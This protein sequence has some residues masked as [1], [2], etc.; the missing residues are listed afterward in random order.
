MS[1]LQGSS[2]RHAAQT[3]ADLQLPPDTSSQHDNPHRWLG[4]TLLRTS[5]HPPLRLTTLGLVAED[6][7]PRTKE[8]RERIAETCRRYD[9]GK[10]KRRPG[11]TDPT[12][13]V[14]FP[15]S[16]ERHS[17]H[18]PIYKAASTSRLWFMLA[19]VSPR[20][21][22]IPLVSS[23]SIDFLS[24]TL[25]VLYPPSFPLPPPSDPFSRLVSPRRVPPRLSARSNWNVR[26]TSSPTLK[27]RKML[28]LKSPMVVV[29]N[30]LPFVLC[31]DEHGKLHRKQCAGGLVT[32]VAPVVIQCGGLWVG[33]PGIHMDDPSQH[34]PESDP[35]DNGPSAGL[36]SDQVVPVH[37]E[38]QMFD[39][40]YNGCCNATFWPLFHSMPDRAVFQVDKWEA[41]STANALF[42]HQTVEAL[43]KLKAQEEEGEERIPLVWIHDY[44]LMLAAN[45]IRQQCEEENL[46]CK[47]GFFL[48]IPFP[49]WDI[50]RLFP[51]DDEVLQGILGCDM[52]G[53][54]IEDYCR[55]FLDCCQR[56]LGFRVDRLH[57]LV[58]VAG[59]TVKVRALPI[60][61]PYK[62][63]EDMANAATRTLQSSLQIILGV[64]RL[65]YTKGII[66]SRI[67]SFEKLLEKHPEHLEK[68]ALLQVAVPSRTDVK[69]YQQ[70]KEQIDLE[71]GRINGR[72]STLNWSPI[73]YIYGCISQDDLAAYYS[74]RTAAIED[75]PVLSTTGG[76]MG[77]MHASVIEIRISISVEG[78]L[79]SYQ[80][81]SAFHEFRGKIVGGFTALQPRS[82]ICVLFDRDSS[83]ALVTPLRDGMNLVAKEYVACQVDKPGVL[84]LSPFAGAGETM[85]EALLVN[86]YELDDVAD[87][88]HRALTMP[89][90]E[91][92]MR[93]NHLRK[94][95][96]TMNL[97]F[98]LSNFLKE[99]KINQKTCVNP[100]FQV[101]RV[102]SE[103]TSRRRERHLFL[104]ICT[105]LIISGVELNLGPNYTNTEQ[106]RLTD[107][108][109]L[110]P[111]R[112]ERRTE[113]IDSEDPPTPSN[114]T[115]E[116][117]ASMIRVTLA[118]FNT[119]AHTTI[120]LFHAPHPKSLAQME[121]DTSDLIAS[122]ATDRQ[123]IHP[124]EAMGSFNFGEGQ[125]EPMT[126]NTLGPMTMED[127]D[128]FLSDY[129]GDTAK[130][131]LL[132]DYDGT[133]APIAPKP[134]IAFMPA[135]TKNILA[136][137]SN[138]SD[139]AIAIVS[140]RSLE[141][142]QKMVG[143]DGITYAGNHGL[144]ILHPDG[145]KFIYPIPKEYHEKIWNMCQELQDECCKD[146]AWI[147]H[148]GPIITYHFRAVPIQLRGTFK[149]KATAIISKNGFKVHRAH[150]AIE[151]RP[152]IQWDKGRASIYILRTMFG[153]DWL[154]RVRV[155]YVGDD[156]TDEDALLALHGMA[157][158]FRIT[159]H[160]LIR[161]AATKRLSSTDSV[162][163][164]LKW[165]ER[166]ISKR[167]MRE[168][169]HIT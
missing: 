94:R 113:T 127:F 96:Q 39:D 143:I 17:A 147:E 22:W 49:P 86:P 169:P 26:A 110:T 103:H 146:G 43:K 27:G 161:T 72:F 140:G 80:G 145:S 157:C 138:S 141:D 16:A 66:N 30:R 59:R 57:N 111:N 36:R 126:T 40:F 151:A 83:V 47:L 155:I 63:F 117:I 1:P 122:W 23:P 62:R 44:H 82:F 21:F 92:E 167:P 156:V 109:S 144:E 115:L 131:A 9:L 48:H 99:E 107:F 54:H 152:P 12:K 153:V 20:L 97:D 124:L 136:R 61:I 35:E 74:L 132:L 123:I 15:P 78:S 125:N 68:V 133:L 69:E 142:V 52:I 70:L 112:G 85:H 65:D 120:R 51:W 98:W 119:I 60:G 159:S 25:P 121:E 166:H 67:L 163:T 139:V 162:L 165:V 168:E 77:K 95:E 100:S 14:P 5:L 6:I 32:A 164:L 28:S 37:M 4:G 128:E 104:I 90:D 116:D 118:P 13:E 91:R 108:F 46:K 2:Q 42:A 19:S 38:E 93:M 134:E 130:I 53:F 114:V 10:H 102:L 50:F 137:L 7:D 73:R 33:W 75:R 56:R 3:S 24:R 106:P 71:V 129:I 158:T 29:S 87:T 149:Q 34:V 101:A 89:D 88:L 11:P 154:E 76:T 150:C 148:K 84:I 41:Y 79:G 135:E 8:R 105:V 81:E 64:D 55:N 45:H 58:D 31:K 160:H 18:C